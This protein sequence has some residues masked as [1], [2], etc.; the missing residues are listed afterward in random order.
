MP[1]LVEADL[2]VVG[3]RDRPPIDSYADRLEGDLNHRSFEMQ[4]LALLKNR[5]NEALRRL[6]TRR[7]ELQRC[8]LDL[9][10]QRVSLGAN[11]GQ[12]RF[13]TLQLIRL[14]RRLLAVRDHLRNAV[15]PATFELG[16]QREPRL[17]LRQPC[18]VDHDHVCV[19]PQLAQRVRRMLR[20]GLHRHP[21]PHRLVV[22]L[23]DSPHGR[24]R[25]PEHVRLERRAGRLRVLHQP[26]RVHQTRVH[27]AQ[28][29]LLAVPQ[30]R[31]GD[32]RR[33]MPQQRHP[34]RALPLIALKRVQST[35]E[36]VQPP[37]HPRELVTRPSEPGKSIEQ[38]Q[39]LAGPQQ[40]QVLALPV[41]IHQPRRETPH[42]LKR[43]RAVV[44]PQPP[45]QPTRRP[46][47]AT[48]AQR[49]PAP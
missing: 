45:G 21:Q 22:Y 43:R 48:V 41:N 9:S 35:I 3:R 7:A 44:D 29:L 5:R 4:R 27:G 26:R 49:Q 23:N 11:L 14:L 34:T 37:H 12:V 1:G 15:A 39:T 25:V 36:R 2:R 13:L 47:P 38:R 18:R 24:Q 8:D 19:G 10:Q 20:G 46:P 33:L 28:F 6:P 32:L 42:R 16:D 40:R 31:R 17:H 30:T